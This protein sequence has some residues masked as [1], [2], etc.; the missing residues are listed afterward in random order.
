MN[1]PGLDVTLLIDEDLLTDEY[2]GCHPCINSSTLKIRTK[3]ILDV[4]LK[5]TGHYPTFVR[6]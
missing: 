4:F 1:D 6:L 2:I 3:D 5:H